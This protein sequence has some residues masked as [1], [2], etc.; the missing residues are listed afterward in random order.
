[1]RRMTHSVAQHSDEPFNQHQ[2]LPPR[3]DPDSPIET[4][5]D[6]TIFCTPVTAVFTTLESHW[7]WLNSDEAATS[8]PNR[9]ME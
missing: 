3:L 2:T 4:E 5:I 8:D 1:M 6:L 7:L 9:G